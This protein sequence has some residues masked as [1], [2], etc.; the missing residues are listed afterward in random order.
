M[1][2]IAL[3]FFALIS[4]FPVTASA[5]GPPPL[6]L[7]EC[8]NTALENNYALQAKREDV[9][10]AKA[11]VGKATS[12][13]LPRL[14]VSETWMRSDN[15]V[16]AF[17]AK[18][19]QKRFTAADFSIDTLNEPAAIDNFNFRVQA[20]QPIFNGGK[21]IVGFRRAK[22]G[23]QAADKDFDRARQ[24]TVNKAIQAYYGVALAGEY[25]KVASLAYRDAK[26]H[27]DLAQKFYGQGMLL[28][29]DLMLAKVR[30]AEMKELLIKAKNQ[31]A[32]AKAALNLVMARP[33]DIDFAVAEP[34]EYKEF[35]WDLKSLQDEALKN[36]PDLQ[37]MQLNV[38][39]MDCGVR[40]AKT[41]YLPNLNFVARYELDD[42]NF[43][44]GHGSS[45]TLLGMV[46]WNVF[47]GFLTTNSVREARA[48]A[49]STRH[50][51]DQMREGVLFDV[52]RSWYNLQEARERIDA[53]SASVKE[54]EE[55]LRVLE[56]RF[57]AGLAKTID[58][59]DAQTA[60]TRARTDRVQ[61]LYDYNVSA[62]A[63]NLAVGRAEQ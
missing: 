34:L 24:E 3:F 38:K 4:L 20:T 53:T 30:V 59:L 22:L 29:S 5:E 47:D 60:L 21:E 19:N 35:G 51:Y 15:P 33:Q 37:G 1:P 54:A 39:N 43:F 52:R 23:A 41:D 55:A 9:E 12:Y 13:F 63:V 26:G 62:A 45:Y 8:I 42:P 6:T 48:R 18:L 16:M 11:G 58:V 17:G 2:I 50:M 57:Q 10:A 27:E 14:D 44:S 28:E 31:E 56:K 49:N 25:V 40:L 7:K 32:T 36:R 61:A 46:S